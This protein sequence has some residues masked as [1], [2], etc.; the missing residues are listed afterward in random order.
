[1]ENLDK[2][3]FCRGRQHRIAPHHDLIRNCLQTIVGAVAIRTLTPDLLVQASLKKLEDV[4]ELFQQAAQSSSPALRAFVS[5]IVLV[6]RGQLTSYFRQPRLLMLRQK[7]LQVRQSNLEDRPSYHHGKPYDELAPLG[8][9]I[10]LVMPER[11]VVALD[12]PL[13]SIYGSRYDL[14]VGS[15]NP[16]GVLEDKWSSDMSQDLAQDVIMGEA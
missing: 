7:A 10:G 14:A 13:S 3:V 8:E 4:C 11:R 9:Q 2:C 12:E 6:I 1:V 16:E 5:I 15:A